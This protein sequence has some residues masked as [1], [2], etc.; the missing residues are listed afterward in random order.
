MAEPRVLHPLLGVYYIA[1][2]VT[3]SRPP[4]F[5][6]FWPKLVPLATASGI[7]LDSPWPADTNNTQKKQKNS[8]A[9][10]TPSYTAGQKNPHRG[11]ATAPNPPP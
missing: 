10:H 9:Y 2:G 1:T 8:E 3:G 11:T 6:P 7:T 4:G 5:G